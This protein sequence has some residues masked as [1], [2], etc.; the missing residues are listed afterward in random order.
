MELNLM[1]QN[2]LS[3]RLRLST[4]PTTAADTRQSQHGCKEV[5]RIT[6]PGPQFSTKYVHETFIASAVGG[7]G[8]SGK[9]TG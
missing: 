9:S 2:P 1:A 4:E 3:K 7:D 5:Y 8:K 6:S